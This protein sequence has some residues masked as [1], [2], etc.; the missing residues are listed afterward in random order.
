VPDWAQPVWHLFV[1]R[2]AQ[3]DQLQAH[4]VNR[5]IETAIHYPVPPHLQGAYRNTDTA[6]KALPLA[7]DWSGEA[8]SLPM[9][10]GVPATTVVS[11]VREFVLG[12][13]GAAP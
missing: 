8:L 6:N 7:L 4:L 5:G 9:W 2:C 10:P 11:A 3:R 13:S 12:Q 1:V